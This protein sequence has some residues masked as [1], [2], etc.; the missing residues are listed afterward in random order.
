MEEEKT[1]W[2][3]TP[4]HWTGFI[5]YLI[6]IPLSIAYGLGVLLA[7]W[8]FLTIWTWKFT[9]TN[10]RLINEKGVLSKKT[11]ELEF[12]RVKDIKLDEPFFLRILGL[13]NIILYTSDRTT[14]TVTI[15]GIRN[16]KQLKEDI[17]SIVDLRREKKGVTER[18]FE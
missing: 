10:Q 17:R 15:P 8:Q 13:S 11:D 4:S 3:G 16:G 7:I 5:Y 14:P 18:D 6:C 9:I 1:I 2:S 12:F